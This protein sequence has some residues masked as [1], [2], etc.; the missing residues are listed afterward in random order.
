MVIPTNQTIKC[1]ITEDH[2]IKSHNQKKV[3][4]EAEETSVW[5]CSDGCWVTEGFVSVRCL[6]AAD[7]SIELSCSYRSPISLSAPST[8]SSF[9]GERKWTVASLY[10]K[11]PISAL[12]VIHISKMVDV[13][14]NTLNATF[15]KMQQNPA[16]HRFR[17]QCL[18]CVSICEYSLVTCSFC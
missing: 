16:K 17:E 7:P 2:N 11:K 5:Y 9:T 13:R 12:K 15:H 3:K 6:L 18:N 10:R 8:A 14:I 1:H 4:T